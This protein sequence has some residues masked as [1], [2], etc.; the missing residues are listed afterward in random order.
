VRPVHALHVLLP[1]ALA[2]PAAHFVQ[3]GLYAPPFTNVP[4]PP[5]QLVV[6][7]HVLFTTLN[8]QFAFVALHAVQA[9]NF[10]YMVVFAEN[11]VLDA[12]IVPDAFM[13]CVV[14]LALL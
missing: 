6:Y 11:V 3:L 13:Y 2:V 14:P 1:S 10:A 7:V 9:L 4:Y 5:L 8:V 12:V